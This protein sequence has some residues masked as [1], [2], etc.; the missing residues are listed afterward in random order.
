MDFEE[1]SP[2]VWKPQNK[3]D[4]IE[5]TL[6][7]K[8]TNVG[9]NESNAYYLE[10][11]GHQTMVWG[12]TVIDDRMTFVNVGDYIRITFKDILENAKKQPLKVFKVEKAKGLGEGLLGGNNPL[13]G[14][15]NPPA[16]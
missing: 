8:R 16:V 11:D 3:G 12:T 15:V 6:V 2:N 13:D 10:K 9:P 7:L 14:L 1:I 4:A 5:G